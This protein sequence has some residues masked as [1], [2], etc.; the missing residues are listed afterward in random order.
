MAGD[1]VHITQVS[2]VSEFTVVHKNC[3]YVDWTS[4]EVVVL[5]R[6]LLKTGIWEVEGFFTKRCRV[7]PTLEIVLRTF[8]EWSLILQL[9][10]VVAIHILS[11]SRVRIMIE[12]LFHM[13]GQYF[14]SLY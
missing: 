4:V 8:E 3:K 12:Q 2:K 6:H 5:H 1:I 14:V 13:F 11:D 9:V 10:G 7:E